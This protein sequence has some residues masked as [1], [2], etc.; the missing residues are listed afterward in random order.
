MVLNLGD[1]SSGVLQ[2][3]PLMVLLLA[4]A[5]SSEGGDT[6]DRGVPVGLGAPVVESASVTCYFHSTGDTFI[7]WNG[8]AT[9]S[10]QQGLGTIE[11]LGRV[12]VSDAGGVIGTVALA[13]A[14]G[15]CA[16]S[17]QGDDLDVECDAVAV[18]TYD[19]AFVVV[20]I[21]GHESAPFLAS[22]QKTEDQ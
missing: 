15:S 21:D 22:A 11:P 16:T 4:C 12:D 17:W 19:F 3:M 6:A 8:A 1:G 13:C 2:R 14:E 18:P 7:Q 5:S 20:D 9:V 10:D